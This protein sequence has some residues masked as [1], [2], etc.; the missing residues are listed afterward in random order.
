MKKNIEDF[1]LI[2]NAKHISEITGVSLKKA[3]E[4]MNHSDFPLI[5]L[6]KSKKVKRDGF[7]EWLDKQ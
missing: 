6:G 7:F 3:H 1:P 4:I 5:R 2:L